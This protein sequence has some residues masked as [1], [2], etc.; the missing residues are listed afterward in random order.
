MTPVWA[1]RRE[2]LLSDC[3]VSPDVFH[4]MVDRLG[5]LWHNSIT[6][7]GGYRSSGTW[8]GRSCITS[9][10]VQRMARLQQPA[11]LNLSGFVAA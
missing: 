2:E 9:I 10:V 8:C 1:Q 3:I 5:E 4:Q 11:S 7:S 6:T